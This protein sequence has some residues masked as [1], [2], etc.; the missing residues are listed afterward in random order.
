MLNNIKKSISL[1]IIFSIISLSALVIT[2]LFLA[3]V[4]INETAF[5]K[6]EVE[7]A[8]IILKTIEP[9][10]AL[11]LYLGMENNIQ[12][13]AK[14][15]TDNPNILSFEIIDNDKNTIYS[16]IKESKNKISETFFTVQQ[17][18][19]QPNSK[20]IIAKATIRYSSEN[21]KKLKNDY[22]KTTIILLASLVLLFIFLSL[23]IKKLLS[24]LR[25]IAKYLNNYN[26][27]IRNNSILYTKDDEIGLIAK[28]LN[29][30]QN[31]ISEYSKKQKNINEN[32]EKMV[33]KKTQELKT[34]LYTNSLT[35][36]PNRLSLVND[37]ISMNE[38]ALII[39][40]IDD[41]KEINDFFGH[42]IGDSILIQLSKKLHYMFY[43]H[44]NIKLVHLNADEFA[45]LFTK[46]IAYST[47]LKI[48]KKLL[49]EVEN[50]VFHHEDSKIV[51]RVTVGAV[52]GMN[53]ILERA[54]IA[55]KLAKK[56]AK[57][58]LIYD[59]KLNIEREY[60]DN[61]KWVKHIKNAIEKDKIVPFF[62]PIFD[63]KTGKLVSC[64]CLMRLIDD[65][66]KVIPPYKFLT[67]A[68]KSRLYTQLTK[69]MI[70]KS[71]NYFQ[72]IECDFSINLSIDD[73]LDQ[74]IVKFLKTQ[75]KRFNVTNK[76]VLE[77]LETE[78]I[79]NYE[80]ISKFLTDMKEMGC[81][82]AIDDFGSGYSNFEYILKLNVDYIKIDGTLIKN[83]D[84][85]KNAK[86]VVETI[87]DFAKK[88]NI[89]TIAEF[90][91]SASIHKEVINLDVTRSQGFYLSEPKKEIKE[92]IEYNH[93][94][95]VSF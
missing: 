56:T 46:R 88:L 40:N 72:N 80:E 7:K 16:F 82:I 83:L 23:Y 68:K 45:L 17:N 54:D 14:E 94:L 81:K 48:I 30:M 64:E 90:V 50:I 24:P 2:I 84:T 37:T 71:C 67:I 66:D 79:E 12:N 33:D 38:G 75:I 55:L 25:N 65:N 59:R 19:Y 15:L 3:L 91:H 27:D 57:E 39:L 60:E 18:I 22:N 44:N 73:M 87:V 1:K 51:I 11:D 62:Q 95:H 13:I 32:L 34:Q 61:I 6:V 4:K 78:G 52:Y 89:L 29:N 63:N 41:F 31:K 5:Y 20:K 58:Y 93:R 10:I 47:F 92:M 70:Q 9:L 43:N 26:P 35:G 21:Y 76:I 77:I 69:I 53:N 86:I 28:E 36:L 42:I 74:E 85:D 49:N 8:T